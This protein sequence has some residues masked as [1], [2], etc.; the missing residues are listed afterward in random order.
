MHVVRPDVDK[1]RLLRR[2][3]LVDEL[4]RAKSELEDA[5]K[6][7]ERAARLAAVGRMSA[8]L[9]HEVGNPLAAILGMIELAQDAEI[10]PEDRAELQNLPS[11]KVIL[12]LAAR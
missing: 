3:G 5:Q 1:E 7:I 4:E 8:G 10:D 2:L 6:Q 11:G 9:A 12:S